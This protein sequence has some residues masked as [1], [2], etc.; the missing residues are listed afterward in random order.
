MRGGDDQ[1]AI[2]VRVD[3]FGDDHA[4]AHPELVAAV[5]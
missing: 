3:V 2:P 5:M 4:A 1:Q